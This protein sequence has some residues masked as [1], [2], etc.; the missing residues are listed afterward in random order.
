MATNTDGEGIILLT[1]YRALV[2]GTIAFRRKLPNKI[3]SYRH[4]G[5]LATYYDALEKRPEGERKLGRDVFSTSAQQNR[6][7]SFV[8]DFLVEWTVTDV[9]RV[10]FLL[11]SGG[12]FKARTEA[13]GTAGT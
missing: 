5:L 12:S 11:L 8:L 6:E 4:N 13:H 2:P 10:L 7:L 1:L 9:Q 3:F